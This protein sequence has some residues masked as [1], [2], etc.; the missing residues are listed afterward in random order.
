MKRNEMNK[1]ENK[2]ELSLLALKR[3][4]QKREP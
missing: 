2:R 3:E 1:N 4:T